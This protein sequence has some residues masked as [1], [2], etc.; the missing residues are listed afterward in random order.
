MST[1]NVCYK[2]FWENCL[3]SPIRR[4]YVCENYVPSKTP[5]ASMR[6]IY[7]SSTLL[8]SEWSKIHRVLAVLSASG[9]GQE[10]HL[11]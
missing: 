10:T 3:L 11:T 8:H 6:S 5:I 7:E 1:H 2:Y 9:L 4:K